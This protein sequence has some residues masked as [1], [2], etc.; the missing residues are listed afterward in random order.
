MK[1]K[2]L[3]GIVLAAT[4]CCCHIFPDSGYAGSEFE[5]RFS[6]LEKDY[7]NIE[8][9]FFQGVGRDSQTTIESRLADG[10][11]LQEGGDHQRAA[12]V[13]MDILSHEAWKVYPE[14]QTAR[15]YLARSLY[16]SGYYRLSQQH[17][18]ELVRDKG[19]AERTEAVM[20]L[21]QV[22][23]KT[24]EWSQ[25]ND[26]LA[27]SGEFSNVPAYAYIMGRAMFLQGKYA[28]ARERLGAV[29]RGDEWG[30]R[31]EY[32]LGVL[33]TIDGEYLLARQAFEKVS[34][35]RI[36]FRGSE[37]IHELSILARA[38]LCYER[39]EW[40]EAV[41]LYHQIPE[42]SENFAA[43]LYELGWTFLSKEDYAAAQQS[44]ELLLLAH[45]SDR[46][47]LEARRILADIKREVGQYDEAVASYQQL[48]N[49]YAP[50]MTRME[51]EASSLDER[52]DRVKKSVESGQFEDVD[53]VPESAR[54]VIHIDKEA[55]K[56]GTMLDSLSESS[57]NTEASER[58][59]EE[60]GAI[61]SDEN[62]VRNMPEFSKITTQMDTL[63]ANVLLLGYELAREQRPLPQTLETA[64]AKLSAYPRTAH[65]RNVRALAV[66]TA[67]EKRE[68]A[69]HRLK[70][71]AENMHYRAKV[72]R[73]WLDNGTV[74]SLNDGELASLKAEIGGLEQSVNRLKDRQAAI[75]KSLLDLRNREGGNSVDRGAYLSDVSTLS[76]NLERQWQ[77]DGAS[78]KAGDGYVGDIGRIRELLSKIDALDTQ[79]NQQIYA[80]AQMLR[81]QLAREIGYIEAEKVRYAIMKG[82]VGEAAGE[83]AARYWQ[84]VYEQVRDMV[85]N[86][87]LGMVDI[88]WLKKEARSK[89]LA[90]AMDAR[91]EA[92]EALETDYRKAMRESGTDGE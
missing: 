79:L 49:E 1:K 2:R 73:E 13:F 4:V 20:L 59:V 10:I 6:A 54:A 17:L 58:I 38:R 34:A 75:E 37:Q 57:D 46:H 5:P 91:R 71:Q 21:L 8:R 35:N 50:V 64:A 47:A 61:L 3:M 83:I 24:G 26:A 74:K 89:A 78:G 7:Q 77:L 44:F 70:L 43:V 82:E 11:V 45:A 68:G 39:G 31:A 22:A 36:S 25:V 92:R 55:G 87:D 19:A 15:F 12:Y 67:R 84:S 62:H 48:V 81:E 52:K 86:A 72:M 80:R 53:I 90:A 65:E 16:E 69:L 9:E 32:L 23:Q 41:E 29:R 60:I 33:D 51:A 88:A 30:V 27:S 40:N 76:S 63:R 42:T 18:L 14:Y 28:E 56:V 66:K 85:L